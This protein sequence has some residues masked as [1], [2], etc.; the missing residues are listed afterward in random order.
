MV[1]QNSPRGGYFYQEAHLIPNS[2]YYHVRNR[3]NQQLRYGFSGKNGG[4]SVASKTERC[5]Y[6]QTLYLIQNMFT[7]YFSLLI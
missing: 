2:V 6:P 4:E 3:R 7:Y 1:S 5:G